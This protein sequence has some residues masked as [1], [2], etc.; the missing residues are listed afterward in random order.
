MTRTVIDEYFPEAFGTIQ[1]TL[2]DILDKQVS[3]DPKISEYYNRFGLDKVDWLESPGTEVLKEI[4]T[5]F[6]YKYWDRKI[7][8]ETME[9][10]QVYLQRTTDKIA[11]KYCRALRLFA[12]YSDRLDDDVVRKTTQTMSADNT[13]SSN[14]K[15]LAYE[16]P[17]TP[18]TLPT[19]ATKGYAGSG[20]ESAGNNT[21]HT[22]STTTMEMSGDVI[23]QL[24]RNIDGWRDIIGE[25][26]DRYEEC[27]LKIEWY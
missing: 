20:S 1:I 6:Q 16:L 24:N 13:G 15:G 7:S 27:F 18:V 11:R 26:V 19:D 25:I 9:Q 12:K 4:E 23:D 14:S 2:G 8:A 5:R 3:Q 21:G 17:D 10:W 22:E